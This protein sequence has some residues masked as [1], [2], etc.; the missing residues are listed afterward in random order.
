MDK[1]MQYTEDTKKLAQFVCDKIS[2]AEQHKKSD[3]ETLHELVDLIGDLMEAEVDRKDWYNL[4][5]VIP[6]EDVDENSIS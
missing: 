2:Y 6:P 3:L 1:N 5:Q 4:C